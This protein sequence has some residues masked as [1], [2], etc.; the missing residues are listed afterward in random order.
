MTAH[1]LTLALCAA[2]VA[3]GL[4]ALWPEA[5]ALLEMNK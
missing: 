5:V 3:L 1:T 4:T 2:V